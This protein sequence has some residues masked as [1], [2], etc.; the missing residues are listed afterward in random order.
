M[1]HANISLTTFAVE[2]QR[3]K[4]TKERISEQAAQASH[5][6]P[7]EHNFYMNPFKRLSESNQK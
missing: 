4:V 1:G 3:N 5:S 6:F 7:N 2:I